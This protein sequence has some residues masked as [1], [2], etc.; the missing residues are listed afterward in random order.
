M[1]RALLGLFCACALALASCMPVLEGQDYHL[2]GQEVRLTLLHTSDIHSRLVPY[3]FTPLKTD[4]DLELIPEAGPFGGATRIA[5]ILKRERAKGDRVLHL[6]S[7][8]C[9]QGAPIFNVNTGEAEFRFLSESRLD[10]AVVGNHEFDA[11]ALNFVQ[12]ARNFAN[13]PLLAANYYWDDP[14]TTGTNGASMV[15]NPYTI[16]TVKGLRVGIIGMANISS[17]NSIV[18]GGNS[19][20]VTPLEQNEAAR[21]YVELLRPVTDLIVIVSHLGLTEDQ[22]LIQGYEAY[23]EYGRAKPF[24]NRAHDAWKVLEWFGPEGN[25]KSVVRVHIAGVSGMDV[26][27]GGHLHVVLNPPQLVTDPAGRKVVLSHSGAFAKY[28]GRLELVVKMPNQRGEENGAEVVSQDYHAFPVDGLWC[29]EAMRK[30]RFDDN[31]F[32]DPGEFINAPGVREA[33]V[34]CGKQEDAQTT[35]LLIPYLLGMDVKLQLTSIFS[36]APLDVQRRNNSNGGDSPLGNIAADSMRKRNRVEAEMALTN[37][38]GIRDNLYA[39]VVT[40]EAMFNVFPFENTINIMYLSGVEM[41]EMFDFVTERSAERGC[42][43]QAQ[44]SGARFTM[45]CAQVQLNDLRIACTPATVATDC[46]QE[47][48]EG[49]APWTCL[50]DTAGSRCWAHTGI[51]IEINGKPLDTNGT[52]KVAVNDYIAKGGSG[53]TV[54]KRNTTRIET[55]ISLRDS[56]IGYMQGFCNCDDLLNGRETSSNGTRCGSLVGGKWTVDEKT[57]NSCKVSKDFEQGLD[58]TVGSCSCRDLL[59]VTD[60]PKEQPA[61]MARCGLPDMTKQAAVEQCALPQGP[62]TGRC[63]CRDLLVGGNPTCGNVTSQLRSFCEKPTAM[64]IASAIE[65]GRIGRRV[66]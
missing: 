16:R 2:E 8:D 59:K 22:D 7:G 62:Y 3:D 43:S 29:N 54:L 14:K 12:K 18:E 11:G 58:R 19:L 36:Y 45:D 52:Y 31:I 35:D 27:L 4:Q 51:D 53:F 24:I 38:L 50:E 42:V 46:P 28:V 26:V 66:K 65:D 48:R 9:F 39:G 41:Q 49:H 64:P 40:Q 57:L 33:M 37:S 63:T 23:Y 34:E 44:I 5:S 21:S 56:L 6:D 20:Q 13:F 55:G 10:A 15:T 30:Y 17:L 25:D 61:A 1:C 32:W 47:N 60:D